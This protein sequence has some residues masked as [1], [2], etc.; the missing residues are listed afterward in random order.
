MNTSIVNNFLKEIS[1]KEIKDV[2][3]T[4][5]RSISD[6][7]NISFKDVVKDK[8]LELNNNS[9]ESENAN[10]DVDKGT[11][12]I[13]ELVAK[14]ERIQESIE[15]GN[16][17][18][19]IQEVV[20]LLNLLNINIVSNKALPI[21]IEIPELNEELIP[22]IEDKSI[23]IDYNFFNNGKMFDKKTV[24]D[25]QEIINIFSKN[26]V[27]NISE[28]SVENINK[29]IDVVLPLVKDSF[30]ENIE[31]NNIITA[32]KSKFEALTAV[33]K[34]QKDV[35]ASNLNSKNSKI[36]D[37]IEFNIYYTNNSNEDVSNE[38]RTLISRGTV[39][40]ELS[41]EDKV[42][43]KILGIETT[44][45]F[46]HGINRLNSRNDIQTPSNISS[47]TVFKETMD[48]DI[49][50]NLRFMVK[51]E[52]QEL[53]VKI[54]PKELGEMTIKIL[55]EEGIMRA[56]IKATSKE[57]YNLLNS[58]INEIKKSLSNENIKIQEVNI[59][60]YNDDTTY[61]SGQGSQEGFNNRNQRFIA[62][63]NGLYISDYEEEIEEVI[64]TDNSNVDLLV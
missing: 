49:I 2:S 47:G 21:I 35:E 45:G 52:I 30:E 24:N 39:S 42:L 57:T 26:N 29:L 60:L 17:D 23:E 14:S 37:K 3:A 8:K 54:Y 16:D 10:K 12:I 41:E 28:Q 56:E 19:I 33:D 22:T 4:N 15:S 55:S 25:V 27:T 63:D 32:I 11:K 40:E 7:N 64:N 9:G 18:E 59:G 62:N 44:E 5:K 20:G 34:D 53:K 13:D 1:T 50:K 31:K 36:I 46:L 43:N 48:E 58:N 51:N 38:F 61:Y 6:K